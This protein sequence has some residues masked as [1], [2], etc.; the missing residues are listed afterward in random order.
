AAFTLLA[1]R[2]RASTVLIAAA[3]VAVMSVGSPQP[4]LAFAAAGAAAA[5]ALTG[6]RSPLATALVGAAVVNAALRLRLPGSS[7]VEVVAAL[8]VLAPVAASGWRTLERTARRRGERA[9]VA[10][11]ALVG[12]VG[13]LGV[14]AL[15]AARPGMER[16]LD[17]ADRGVD[18]ARGADRVR[19]D[20]ELDAAG[21]AFGGAGRTLGA[22]WARP[23]L[24][25]PVLGAH[26]RALRVV[27]DTGTDLADAGRQV[28]DAAD[29]GGLRIEDGR[30]PLDRVA[31][32]QGPLGR[33]SAQVGAAVGRLDRARSV[34]LAPPVSDRLAANVTRLRAAAGSLR[35]SRDVV[36]VLPRLLGA[37][38]P[39]RW[40][41]AMQ[42]PSE[43]RGSGGF[44]GNY[45]EIE[46]VD[47]R[48]ELARF[49]RID[50]LNAG[51]DASTRV[52]DGPADVLARYDRFETATTWQNVTLSPDFPSVTKVI[53]GLYPQSG[54]RPVE[55]VIAVDPAGVAA[56]LRL[57]GP[58]VVPP[59]PE[60]LTAANAERILLYEQYVRLP[61]PER[62]DFLGAAT[63]L[64]WER[65]TT[66]P[67]PSTTRVLAALGPAVAG[68]HIMVS[69]VDGA[70]DAVLELAGITGRLAPVGGSDALAV[71]T[72]NAN[73]NKID[74]FLR[75]SI[76]YRPTYDRTTGAL[77][78]RLTVTLDNAA[79][80]AGLPDYLIA[81]GTTPPLPAGTNRVY[82]SVYT[83]LGLGAARVNGEA[84]ALESETEL[85]RR[86]YS[87]YVDIPP[88][89]RTVVQ[90][91]LTGALRPGSP[92]A[93]GV[94]AQPMVHPD[95]MSVHLDGRPAR[96]FVLVRDRAIGPAAQGRTS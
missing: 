28:A 64:L 75:R 76:D 62:I 48:L 6:G 41:L 82:L 20:R 30:V 8:A 84:V 85:G 63:Q 72:Q 80:P 94:H 21:R 46:A 93:L 11:G 24:A 38:R 69:S 88:Q 37:E 32:L 40:F 9:A 19:A 61:H 12:V 15:A 90:L 13:L 70:E 67:L 17:H 78:A 71:V 79:P 87:A 39:R 35:S 16:A 27:A 49:G 50:E 33:A 73:G 44:V 95:R 5:A 68:K 31:A 74:W 59:W 51:G 91:D 22:W 7:P 29:L 18:A 55:G 60:P 54:G 3:A 53:A 47:G 25:V 92:Y 43:A 23:A 81:S 34:W 52:L 58:L 83:P 42:T 45:G 89:G 66:G 4:A 14:V 65:L 1:V 36:A 56:V 86:V 96:P 77:S 2:A 10:A 26:L 57:T